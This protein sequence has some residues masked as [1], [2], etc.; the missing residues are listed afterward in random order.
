M[1]NPIELVPGPRCD[2][3]TTEPTLP[4]ELRL[5]P[6]LLSPEEGIRLAAELGCS[7]VILARELALD[8]IKK[9]P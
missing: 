6:E 7:R 3:S 5:K 1:P 4:S 9:I 2:P 8:E